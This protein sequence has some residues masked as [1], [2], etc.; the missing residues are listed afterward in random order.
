MIIIIITIIIIVTTFLY[1][2]YYYYYFDITIYDQSKIGIMP[3]L[4]IVV[5]HN[6]FINSLCEN[7][8]RTNFILII[9]KALIKDSFS[10]LMT[11]NGE[12]S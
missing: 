7:K 1:Y 11:C 5:V 4:A 3:Y 6:K 12:C 10:L 8:I 2:Y 9:L